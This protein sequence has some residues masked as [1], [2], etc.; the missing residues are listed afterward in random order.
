MPLLN[1]CGKT[2][3]NTTFN[4]AFCFLSGETE[5][6]FVWA[7][8]ALQNLVYR[9]CNKGREEASVIGPLVAI[10]DRDTAQRKAWRRVF[11]G[12][13]I[14]AC[15]W[16]VEKNVL[17]YCQRNIWHERGCDDLDVFLGEWRAVMYAKTMLDFEK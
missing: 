12:V 10:A 5:A 14:H 3:L 16:H 15:I 9:P 8:E 17:E 6:D 1:V 13:P 11:P 2:E 4:I 7:F